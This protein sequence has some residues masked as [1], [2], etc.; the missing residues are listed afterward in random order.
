MTLTKKNVQKLKNE[1][2]KSNKE[3]EIKKYKKWKNVE[4]LEIKQIK[5]VEKRRNCFYPLPHLP[6]TQQQIQR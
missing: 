1:E 5:N 2:T 4:S 6:E 3:K